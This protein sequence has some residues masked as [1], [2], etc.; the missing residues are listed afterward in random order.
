M[1][2]YF[3]R[4]IAGSMEVKRSTNDSLLRFFFKYLVAR[5]T[6]YSATILGCMLAKELACD[7]IA[8]L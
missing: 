1:F 6:H 2:V 3:G 7:S 5:E 8:I 4:A